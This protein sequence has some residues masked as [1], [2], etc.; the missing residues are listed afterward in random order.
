[1]ELRRCGST[2]AVAAA[3]CRG[4]GGLPVC[5]SAST[6][7]GG[8]GQWGRA[9]LS[10]A[11]GCW[12]TLAV[13]GSVGD[14]EGLPLAAAAA[15]GRGIRAATG[16]EPERVA[17]NDLLIGGAKVAGLLCE[18]LALAGGTGGGGGATLVGVGINANA[19]PAAGAALRR[20]AA[21]LAAAAGKRIDLPRLR[22]ACVAELLSL[23]M[24]TP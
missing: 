7:T 18:R 22:E 14:G 17:P 20:P 4:G 16:L 2:N 12:F 21:S 5:V 19:V 13:S 11:G 1:M 23:R 6:Q 8:R 10:P 9:W 24:P 15:V 3:W